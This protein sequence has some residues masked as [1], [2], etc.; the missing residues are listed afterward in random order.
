[1]GQRKTEDKRADLNRLHQSMNQKKVEADAEVASIKA[2]IADE[3]E[4][5]TKAEADIATIHRT[6]KI[7]DQENNDSKTNTAKLEA[8]VFTKEKSVAELKKKESILKAFLSGPLLDVEHLD[9]D[10]AAGSGDEE[11]S[12]DDEYSEEV[13]SDEEDPDSS[14][15]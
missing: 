12:G 13:S 6:I 8:E 3:Q 7:M 4:K 10:E 15:L 5:K 14:T 11:V 1:M 2:R 9:T